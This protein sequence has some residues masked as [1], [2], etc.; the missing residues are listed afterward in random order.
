MAVEMNRGTALIG[1]GRGE[2]GDRVEGRWGIGGGE[3]G[4]RAKGGGGQGEGRWG[5]GRREVGHRAKGGGVDQ[6]RE[7]GACM[8]GGG[9][10]G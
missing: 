5:T 1:A 9:G 8:G 6:V 2:V 10:P 4:D 7:V 3:V